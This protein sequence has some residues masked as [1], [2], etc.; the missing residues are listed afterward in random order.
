VRIGSLG[1]PEVQKALP[2]GTALVQ[3]VMARRTL[4]AFVITSAKTSVQMAA[5][6]KDRVFD[7]TREFAELLV[8]RES[9]ADSS[10]SQQAAIDQRVREVNSPL[11]EAFIR[12]IE[13]AI[14]GIPNVLV[15][16]PRE[17]PWLPLHAITGG[18]S[19]GGAFLA[20]QHT[21]SYLP[22]A[23]AL[24]LPRGTRRPAK[25]VVALG[26]PGG[27][28]WDVEYE[29]R[30]IRAFY[31]DVR[32][33]FDQYASLATLQKERGDV[34]HLAARF[35]FNEERPGN[36]CFIVSDG[37]SPAVMKRVPTVE[38]LAVPPY[39][40]VVIS[41]LDPGRLGIRPAE[42]YLFMANGSQQIVFTSHTPSRKTKK[43]FGEHF[44]TAL[45]SGAD[46]RAAYRKAQLE[47]IKTPEYAGPHVWAWFTL[48][49][50]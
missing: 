41:D 49:G 21:I 32:L 8:M 24:L 16:L 17:L 14:L 18:P 31:K 3:H 23:A 42:P 9:Y 6:E 28:T 36:S 7:I 29:L 20:E 35:S 43:M 39:A 13:S 33:Y 22:S 19:R 34:L 40:T 30:D 10:K 46:T 47:M 48:W 27:T 1:I 50:K 4:Y 26:Y 2:A 15:V 12:P 44:Y 37:K 45:L 25:E 11:F 38:L 5:F